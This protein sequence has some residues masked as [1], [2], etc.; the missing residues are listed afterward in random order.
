MGSL[1]S[2]A[3]VGMAVGVGEGVVR[4]RVGGGG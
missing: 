3:R 2:V 4:W 1:E